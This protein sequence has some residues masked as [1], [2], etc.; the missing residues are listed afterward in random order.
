[1]GMV[2]VT[3][4]QSKVSISGYVRDVAS[5]EALSGA[6]V[7]S[8]AKKVGAYTNEY[9]FFSLS[10]PADTVAIY[11][12]FLGYETQITRVDLRKDIQLDI[13]LTQADKVLKDVVI[14]ANSLAEKVNST[15]MS[16]EQM[17]MVQVKQIPA[18][19]GEVDVLRTLQ[20]KPGVQSG[21]EGNSGI[22][23]RGGGPDQ[24]L[25]LVDE[26][27]VY[28]PSHLFGLFSTFNGDAVKDVRL[29]KGG[30]PAEYGGRLS[31]VIDVRMRE[32][33]MRKFSASGGIGLIS[34][35]LTLETPI[36]RDKASISVSG[37]RTYADIITRQINRTQEDNPDFNPIPDYYFYD[38]NG[39]LTLN[40]GEKDQVFISGYGG[41]DIFKFG[42][43]NFSA[44]FTWGNVAG[45]AHWTHIFG[46][47]TFLKTVGTFS[48]YNYKL[49]NTFSGFNFDLSS[50]VRDI[51]GKSELTI[52]PSAQH[53]IKAGGQYT[54]HS[55]S[56]GRFS[57]SADDG[58]L[59]FAS[60]QDFFGHEMGIYAN[61][62][63]K[64]NS[65][66]TLN[67][68]VRLSGFVSDGEFF[69][70]LEPRASVKYNLNEK[71]SLKGG[72]TRMFQYVHLVSNSGASLPTDIWYPSNRVVQPQRAD[73]VALGINTLLGENFILTDEIYY[74]WLKNQID[75]RDGAQIFFNPNLNNEFVFGR[76]W[77]YGNEIYFEKTKGDGDG[78]FDRTSG[79]IGYTLSWSF[80]EFDA[81]NDGTPFFPRYDRR[82]DISVVIIQELSKRWSVTGSWV[83]GTGQAISLPVAWYFNNSPAPD[84]SPSIV[85]VYTERNGFRMPPYHRGD[86]GVV[87]KMFPKWG[88][89]DIT[90]S[91]YNVYNRRNPFFLFFDLET[92]E[93]SGTDIEI[94]NGFAIRQVS[95]FPVIPSFTF[96]F[97]F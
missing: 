10:L 64:V 65:R 54:Y 69:Y 91:V 15:Q 13:E 51:A 7:F 23:V 48:D 94:V 38:L 59:D 56:V 35:R 24:N 36:V 74:K 58:S 82:H 28:N 16:M 61:E 37:R 53:T 75:F 81:I 89:A 39:K 5:G 70:G 95:L 67:G 42:T 90:L 26:A 78:F 92:E 2:T 43:D 62:E 40:L 50:G 66:L 85:P 71:T 79:W 8:P 97:K 49:A 32:G 72:Y 96:N 86:L 88:E 18:L 57:A 25:F 84:E 3:T 11:V 45:S 73:Q 29:F 14:E 34:S 12:S 1:M 76:G 20:L 44:D 60:G 80:R 27:P 19:F 46:P 31:S 17:T 55:F 33:N 87:Y 22:Y 63:F 4:A 83:Y 41:R 9:G 6:S 93:I 52:L 77:G 47:R 21:G 30:F 68:G